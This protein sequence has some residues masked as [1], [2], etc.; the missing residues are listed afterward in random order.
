MLSRTRDSKGYVT[1]LPNPDPDQ[2]IGAYSRL[3]DLV[4]HEPDD[5]ERRLLTFLENR[6]VLAYTP[7]AH[8][9]KRFVRALSSTLDRHVRRPLPNHTALPAAAGPTS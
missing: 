8:G 4:S 7:G 5:V 6:Q 3:Q 2:V 1:N 9:T